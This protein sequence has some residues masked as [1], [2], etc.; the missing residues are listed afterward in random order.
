MAAKT[1]VGWKLATGVFLTDDRL[2]VTQVNRTPLGVR[3]EDAIEEPVEGGDVTAAMAR[4]GQQG[5]LKG[6]VVC[7]IDIRR[8][9]SITRRLAPDETDRKPAELLASRLGCAE[10]AMVAAKETLK[11]PGG[12]LALLTACPRPVASQL[13]AGLGG[14]RAPRSRL[15]SATVALHELALHVK[16]RSRRAKSEIRVL[17]GEDAW[18]ALLSCNGSLVAA[19]M[20]GMPE[21]GDSSAIWLA[22]MS[23]VTHAHEELGLPA[24]DAVLLHAGENAESLARDCA[25]GYHIPTHVAPR[26]STDPESVS[27]ALA[28]AGTQ[29]QSVAADL[30]ADLRPPPGLRQAFPVKAAAVVL[31]VIAGAGWMLLHEAGKL[32]DEN[33]KLAQLTQKYAQKAK[34]NPK[35]LVKVHE[36]LSGEFGIA[37]SFITSRVFW[38]DVLRELPTVVPSTGTIVDLDG[39]DAVKFPS[40]SKKKKKSEVA[41][42]SVSRQFMLSIEVPLDKADT[43]PP[44]VAELTGA[45]A[46]SPYFLRQFP[47]I[48]GS[49]VRLLPAIKGLAARITVMC[50]PQARA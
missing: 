45:L 26:V 22:V 15:T 44:E 50:F 23:L 7:G 47:R 20:F 13:L 1:L 38:S 35:E 49:N 10:D 9:Y 34:V 4:L 28:F 39:R 2:V 8:D 33:D 40:T 24:I 3:S 16:P 31:A 36:A 48:T 6:T 29:P 37:S 41:T 42:T 21:E 43:S 18:M 14:G 12:P 25:A 27:F 30:F 19:R 32:E 5:R 17:P 11:L 46:T